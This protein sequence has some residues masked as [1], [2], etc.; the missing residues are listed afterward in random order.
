MT[1]VHGLSAGRFVGQAVP[2]K[3]DPRLLTGRG[4]AR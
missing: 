1:A 4:S 3:E 2:R